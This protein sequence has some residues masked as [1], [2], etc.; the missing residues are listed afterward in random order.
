M[1]DQF[2]RYRHLSYE[3]PEFW[4]FHDISL[5]FRIKEIIWFF[6]NFDGMPPGMLQVDLK[7]KPKIFGP[8]FEI[9]PVAICRARWNSLIV[10]AI[11]LMKS[12]EVFFDSELK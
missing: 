4:N 5:C 1:S 8:V 9:S 12:Q 10:Y 7:W 11:C 6:W 3:K 2:L